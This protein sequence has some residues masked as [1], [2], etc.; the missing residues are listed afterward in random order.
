MPGRMGN[1][2]VTVQSLRVVKVDVENNLLLVKGAIPGAKEGYV[3]IKPAV[4]K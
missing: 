1:D 3:T 2:T 4:K